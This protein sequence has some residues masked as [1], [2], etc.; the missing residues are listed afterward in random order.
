MYKIPLDKHIVQIDDEDMDRVLQ[1]KWYVRSPKRGTKYCYTWVYADGKVTATSLHR[2]IMNRVGD[3][4]VVIDHID[5]DGLNNQKSNLRVCSSIENGWN[6][7]KGKNNTSGYKGVSWKSGRWYARIMKNN[8]M[9]E[10]GAYNNTEDAAFAYDIA[11]IYLFG[12]FSCTNFD[13]DMYEGLDIET[14][15]KERLYVP[16]CNYRG[17]VKRKENKYEV[18]VC[19]NRKPIYLGTFHD[20][21]SAALAYD[22]KAYELLGDRAKLNFPERIEEYKANA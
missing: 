22:K 4:S 18:N 10:L 1:K 13:K 17:V 15:Y 12:E 21:L 14:L 3:N 6:K 11:A 7:Q 9:Y 8:L 19:V 20:A 5:H 2:F 16:S